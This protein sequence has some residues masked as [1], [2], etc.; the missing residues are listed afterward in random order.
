MPELPCQ[1]PISQGVLDRISLKDGRSVNLRQIDPR[2][3]HALQAFVRALSPTSRAQRFHVG[4]R[5]LSAYALRYLTN[6]DQKRH[7]AIV[8]T[9]DDTRDPLPVIVADARYV[10]LKER[11]G[12]E[13]A[14]AVADEWQGLGLGTRMLRQLIGTAMHQGMTHLSGAIVH[15]N[16]CM[17]EL[18]RRL[19]ATVTSAAGNAHACLALHGD[20]ALPQS[21]CLDHQTL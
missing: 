7:V 10:E 11:A 19:G 20:R 17:L 8:A 12:A 3:A 2:D 15:D 5:E 4:I 21:V 16:A 1:R 13:V 18:A 6:V 14:I 9:R